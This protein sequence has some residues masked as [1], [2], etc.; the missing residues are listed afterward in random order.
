MNRARQVVPD[1]GETPLEELSLLGAPLGGVSTADSLTTCI[2]NIKTICQRVGLLDAHWAIF[3][4]SRYVSAP[5]VS[6]KLRTS[7]LYEETGAL[8]AI[9]ELVRQ[10]LSERVN[11]A[12]DDSAWKQATLPVRHGGLGVRSV[13]ALALPCYLAS[14][15]SSSDLV[16]EILGTAVEL[17]GADHLSCALERFRGDYPMETLPDGD[18]VARQRAWDDVASS[19]NF[20]TLLTPANQVHRA[21][22]LAAKSQHS[23]SW[24]N[25]TPLSSLGLHLDD[26]SV[27]VAVALR[28]GVPIYRSHT[29]RCGQQIGELGHHGLSCRFSE[30]RLPRHANLND[31]V[32]R[33]LSAAGVPSWLEPVGLDRGDGKRPDGVTIYPYARGMSLCWDST[34]ADTFCASAVLDTAITPGAAADRREAEKRHKYREISRRYVFEPVAVETTGVLG[35]STLRFLRGLGKRI[36]ACTG[37]KRETRWLFER[38][39]LAVVRGNTTSIM[40]SCRAAL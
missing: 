39:S 14:M 27:Q 40:A 29:C 9:D 15:Y 2:N 19:A 24:L 5:R 34:C 20:G 16:R 13:R 21:R 18:A 23:G 28:L 36:S 1:I 37:D 4:L 11:V 35:S 38:I 33:A 30:G 32:K 3:F 25:A 31:V 10:T 26:A 8:D 12:L 22:L 6:Y 7:P 17:P